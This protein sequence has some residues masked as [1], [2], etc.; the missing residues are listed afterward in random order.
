MD[1]YEST[2]SELIKLTFDNVREHIAPT[3]AIT[4]AM[5]QQADPGVKIDGS[6]E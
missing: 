5:A 1:G 2:L 4:T 3:A 6:I